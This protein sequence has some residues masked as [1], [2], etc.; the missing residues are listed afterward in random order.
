M[1]RNVIKS[2]I[3]VTAY[4]RVMKILEHYGIMS[5]GLLNF[6]FLS[7]SYFNLHKMQKIYFNKFKFLQGG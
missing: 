4:M 2:M 5:N 1:T 7:E 6:L 3:C